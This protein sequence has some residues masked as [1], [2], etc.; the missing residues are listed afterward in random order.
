MQS[1]LFDGHTNVMLT[2]ANNI[3]SMWKSDLND[4]HAQ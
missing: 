1:K 3:F 4:T 2:A